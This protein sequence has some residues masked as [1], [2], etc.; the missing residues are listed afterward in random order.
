MLSAPGAFLRLSDGMTVMMSSR[1]ITIG[2]PALLF[3]FMLMYSVSVRSL[4]Q[5]YV[6][7]RGNSTVF[8]IE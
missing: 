5:E 6:Q 2:S 4:K 3:A 1:E 7:F 8:K